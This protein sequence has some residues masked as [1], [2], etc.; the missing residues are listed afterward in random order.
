MKLRTALTTAVKFFLALF[1]VGSTTHAT[2]KEWFVAPS[3]RGVDTNSGDAEHPFA[4]I[5]KGAA[6]A[7]A[8]DTVWVSPGTYQPA[9]I[10]RPARSGTADSPITYRARG[11]E[12]IIDGRGKVPNYPW[13][14]VFTIGKKSWIVLDGLHV[15]NSH[16]FGISANDATGVTVQNC[17]TK[18]T[19][20]SGI[21]I[22][23]SSHVKV[24]HN[25]V[26]GACRH[27][28]STP[29]KDTQECLSLSSCTE[30][31]VACNTIFDRMEDSNNGG[32]GIDTKDACRNGK[33]HH[34]HVFNLVRLGIYADSFGSRLENV[35]IYANTVHDCC[36]G[37]V[38]ACENGG[39]S[40][41]V[42]IHDNLVRDC[43]RLGI[44]LAGYVKNGPIQDVAVYQNTI[45][46]CG[47]GAN[48]WENSGLLVEANNPAN[49]NFVIRNNIF[50][51]NAN[52]I[53][54]RGQTYLTIDRNLLH[55][56]SLVTGA[57]VIA[58]DP[59]FMDA[60]AN[61]FRLS[62]GSPAIGAALGEPLSTVDHDDHV[63]PVA[64]SRNR[65]VVSDLGA[66]QS[67]GSRTGFPAQK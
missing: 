48:P 4:T 5:N 37:I 60:R 33:V 35:E 64:G 52:Q 7:R 13:D 42:T 19:L 31:E 18:N 17:S 55:G 57:H 56:P 23:N 29:L 67:R 61:D 15:I 26:Q 63:R 65:K 34:N 10:I 11:G 2:A 39:T 41:G 28:S 54:T 40:R 36:S 59:L 32:E 38:A 20:A 12:V 43:P 21:Y 6:F 30:F 27:P 62:P 46:R 49:R 1:L 66:F 14:G 58:A 9:D 51:F 47:F 44:R 53:R 24:L 50:A 3:P 25:S 8:G 45:V 22:R 16:W